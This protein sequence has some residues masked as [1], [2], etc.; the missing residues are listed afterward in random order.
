MLGRQG[1]W[2]DRFRVYQKINIETSSK[3]CVWFRPRISFRP[4]SEPLDR[5]QRIALRVSHENIFLHTNQQMCYWR[6]MSYIKQVV[7]P[8]SIEYLILITGSVMQPYG[9]HALLVKLSDSKLINAGPV[10]TQLRHNRGCKSV[11]ILKIWHVAWHY[12]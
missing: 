6:M 12:V 3:H 4:S 10:E 11:W 1:E 5:D 8:R 7:C 2:T 9:V